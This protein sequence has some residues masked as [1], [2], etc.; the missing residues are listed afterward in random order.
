LS[1]APKKIRGEGQVEAN[2]LSRP[3][4]GRERDIQ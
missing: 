4:H 3:F 1:R 2:S